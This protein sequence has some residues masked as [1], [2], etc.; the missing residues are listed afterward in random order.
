M[1]ED[2]RSLQV[3]VDRLNEWAKS[4]QLEYHVRKC[5]VVHFGRENKKIRELVKYRTAAEYGQQ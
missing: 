2:I 4:W 3:D 5:E 1:K